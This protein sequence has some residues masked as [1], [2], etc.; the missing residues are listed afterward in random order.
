MQ[1]KY[2]VTINQLSNSKIGSFIKKINTNII[3]SVT[4]IYLIIYMC[5][6]SKK[7]R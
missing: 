7:F 1:P 5:V 3:P 2:Y 6:L 4:Y